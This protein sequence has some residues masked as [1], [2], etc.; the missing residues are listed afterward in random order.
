MN[1]WCQQTEA[2][3]TFPNPRWVKKLKLDRKQILKFMA[4]LR[5]SD[6]TKAARPVDNTDSNRT[7]SR[8]LNYKA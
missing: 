6:R 5:L 4:L 2:P 8:R 3:K 1:T 7:G